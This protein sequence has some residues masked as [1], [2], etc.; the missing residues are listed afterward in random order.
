[1][2]YTYDFTDL[3]GRIIRACLVVFVCLLDGHAGGEPDSRNVVR[4]DSRK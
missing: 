2:A 4:K 1:M 3:K